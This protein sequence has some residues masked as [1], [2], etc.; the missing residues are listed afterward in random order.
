V[1]THGEPPV[2]Q[3]YVAVG[4]SFTEGLWD[5]P[6]G[7][8]GPVRG[9]ADVLAGLLSERRRAAGAEPLRYANLA[10]RGRLLRPII[11]EQLPQ[12]LAMRPDL[13]SLVGGGNDILRPASDPDRLARTLEQAVARVRATGADVLL[14]TGFD[15]SGSAIV[16]ATRPRVGVYNAHIWSIARRHGAY[17]LDLWGMRHLRDIRMWSPDRI[18]LTSEAHARVAQGALVALGLEPDDAGWDEPLTP[19]PRLPRAEQARLDARW[20]RLYAYPWAT[21]RL[22]GQ[23]SGDTRMAKLPSLTEV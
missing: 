10:V 18:H 16:S 2:W 1:T 20:L 3:R 15:S 12:A 8:D 19:R 11:A 6:E 5:S 23:S 22:R 17:V 7:E 21:R 4:D 13:V 9:W 14:A